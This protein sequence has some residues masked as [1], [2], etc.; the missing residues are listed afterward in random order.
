YLS[1]ALLNHPAVEAAYAEWRASVAAIEPA[2]ALPDPQL[3]FQAD[4]AETLTSLMPGLMFDLTSAGKRTAQGRAAAAGAEVARRNFNLAAQ[5]VARQLRE[6]W[7]ELAYV[8]AAR[9][10]HAAATISVGDT[11]ALAAAAQATGR[12]GGNL[13]D[14]I[15]LQGDLAEHHADHAA[16]G[17]RLQAARL[18]F[19]AALGLAPAD[20]DPPWPDFPLSVEPLPDDQTVW[21]RILERNPDLAALR[22]LVDQSVAAVAVAESAA[23]PDFG[24]GAMVD[25]KASPLLVRPVANLSLPI[26]RTRLDHQVAAARAQHDAALAQVDLNALDLAAR[27]ARALY[28]VHQ[29]DR[30][31][32]YIDHTARPNLDRLIATRSADYES[33]AGDLAALTTV[34]TR[35]ILLRLARLDLL[36]ERADA[37]TELRFLSADAAPAD[38]SETAS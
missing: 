35:R 29:A 17:D 34:A 15:E 13:G 18:A 11:G 8:A 12:P 19:K 6:T 23:T 3:T 16:L 10:L 30:M 25:F 33:G 22:A 7:I 26:W 36:R 24:L 32:A 4:I 21:W 28:T 9:Q 14:L 37:V 2:A 27:V 5:T 31:L 38:L 1:F 20:H